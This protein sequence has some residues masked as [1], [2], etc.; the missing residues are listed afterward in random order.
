V[1][2]R[3]TASGGYSSTDPAS[4]WNVFFG[5][6]NIGFIPII[7]SSRVGGGGMNVLMKEPF[8]RIDE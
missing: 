5:H 4:A 2:N 3:T 1:R 6:S 8:K 7:E